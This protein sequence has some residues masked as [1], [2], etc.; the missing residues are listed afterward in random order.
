MVTN[1]PVILAAWLAAKLAA[2]W[3]RYPKDKEDMEETD[4][5]EPGISLRSS[6]E[7]SR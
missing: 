2:S 7:L 1:G 6:S 5:C 4:K 3:Q